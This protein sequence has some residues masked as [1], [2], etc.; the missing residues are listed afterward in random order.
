MTFRPTD[1]AD[2]SLGADVHLCGRRPHCI[3]HRHFGPTGPSSR[4][5]ET[6]GERQNVVQQALIDLPAETPHPQRKSV[7]FNALPA[8]L[9]APGD[10]KPNAAAG[11]RRRSG[12]E[13][14]Q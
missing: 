3:R 1:Q 10:P 2:G 6:G 14:Q 7:F 12:I 5:T 9:R 4:Q 13:A 8:C 11:L